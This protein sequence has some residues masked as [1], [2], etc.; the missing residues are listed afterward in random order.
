MPENNQLIL[1]KHKGTNSLEV[2]KVELKK[3]SVYIK[4]LSIFVIDKKF[5]IE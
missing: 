4:L 5:S 3:T 1:A 2:G